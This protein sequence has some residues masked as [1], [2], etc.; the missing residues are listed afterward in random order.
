VYTSLS[1]VECRE[2]NTFKET[3]SLNLTKLVAAYESLFD[4]NRYKH[5]FV[6]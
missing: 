1:I 3:Y 4:Q 6:L 2:S 5:V